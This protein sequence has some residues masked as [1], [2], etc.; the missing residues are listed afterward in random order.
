MALDNADACE[1]DMSESERGAS[2]QFEVDLRRHRYNNGEMLFS[3][4]S[5]ILETVNDTI[6]HGGTFVLVVSPTTITLVQRP[7]PEDLFDARTP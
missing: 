7:Q 6:A 2:M 5:L 4:K 1:A 3:H